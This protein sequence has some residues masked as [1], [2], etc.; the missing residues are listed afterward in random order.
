[1]SKQPGV[2]FIYLF[3]TDI[4]AIRHFYT[5]LLGLDEIYFQDDPGG[6]VAYMCDGLQFAFHTNPQTQ[7]A[8]DGWAWQPGYEGGTAPVISWSVLI[9]E[10]EY[11]ST[12]QRLIN[13]GVP[14]IYEKPTWNYYWGFPVKDP[15]GNTVEV[16]FPPDDEPESTEWSW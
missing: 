4:N 5:E 10:D 7:A 15:M 8:G 11:S 3:C 14:A 16:V 13:A 1:M 12:V 6:G 9:T 2:K